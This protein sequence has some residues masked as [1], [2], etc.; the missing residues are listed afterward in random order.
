[1]A[2]FPYVEADYDCASDLIRCHADKHGAKVFLIGESGWPRP[3]RVLAYN[4]EDAKNRVA[5]ELP[6]FPNPNAPS[7]WFVRDIQHYFGDKVPA[8][9]SAAQQRRL[10]EIL[11]RAAQKA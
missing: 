8:E 1:M 9:I 5:R 2:D 6:P 3:I 7:E 10:A 4:W 11:A